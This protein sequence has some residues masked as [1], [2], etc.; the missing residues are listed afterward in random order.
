MRLSS[1]KEGTRTKLS[2]EAVEDIDQLTELAALFRFTLR[3]AVGNT[4]LDVKLENGEADTVERGLGSRKLLKE[5]DAQPRLLHHP[6]DASNLALD[7]VQARDDSLLLRLVEH[8]K[9]CILRLGFGSERYLQKTTAL[10]RFFAVTQQIRLMT[11]AFGAEWNAR[12]RRRCLIDGGG[13]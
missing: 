6:A 5:L 13:G 8:S 7:T 4:P 3:D 12:V 10:R 2:G 11:W 1:H 9:T